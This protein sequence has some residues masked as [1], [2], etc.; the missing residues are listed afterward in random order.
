MS[1]NIDA[2]NQVSRV[3]FMLPVLG[4]P[5][6][7]K[8]ISMLQ[9]NGFYVEVVAFERDYHNGRLPKCNVEILG[10][11]DKGQYFRRA[12]KLLKIIPGLRRAIRRNH[13]VYTF[14]SDMA[15]IAIIASTGL[16]RPIILEI[17]DIQRIQVS[18]GLI[19]WVVRAL[20]KSII[21]SISLL[22]V[23][24][25][26][27]L[28]GYYKDW[29]KVRPRSLVIENKL[30]PAD[31]SI[32]NT[33]SY[34]TTAGIQFKDRPLRIGYFGLLRCD[35]SWKVLETLA[36]DKGDMIEVIVAGL[37]VVPADIEKRAEKIPN[38][39]FLGEYQSPNDLPNLYGSV[40]IIWGCYPQPKSG[41]CNWRWARTN[42]F[43][44]SCY[45]KKPIITLAGSGD[46]KEVEHLEIGVNING[47][48][49]IKEI[50]DTLSSIK[51][52]ELDKWQKNLMRLPRNIY[53]YTTETLELSEQLRGIISSKTHTLQK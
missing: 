14:G 7:A 36:I 29:L 10:K 42:R 38:I 47:N 15:L 31:D 40:D 16:G 6:H 26:G 19:G 34:T 43:Y 27:Y 1:S 28:E 49:G 39:K 8:R 24:A 53:E 23:T 22:V 51:S 13:L 48:T 32:N 50:I 44:E 17:G 9:Q 2:S 52:D 37:P 30:E 5:R 18:S 41:D 20:D 25:K 33:D 21:K 46:A 4:Q 3:L 11:V 45:F 35:W 12:V